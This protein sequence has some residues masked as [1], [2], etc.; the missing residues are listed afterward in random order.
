MTLQIIGE[1]SL[2]IFAI[3]VGILLGLSNI[4]PSNGIIVCFIVAVASAAALDY[5]KA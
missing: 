1:L 4:K 2:A 3:T 5:I